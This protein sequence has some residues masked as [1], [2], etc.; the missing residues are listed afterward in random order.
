MRL[1]E[2]LVWGLAKIV[3]NTNG[4]TL[5]VRIN[6]VVDIL[7]SMVRQ[8]MKDIDVL[9][10]SVSALLGSKNEIDPLVKMTTYVGTLESLPVLGYENLGIPFGPGWQLYIVDPPTITLSHAK[11]VPIAVG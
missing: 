3:Y 7:S 1:G 4:G 8:V 10:G 11:I 5:F 9:D 6:D 2:D